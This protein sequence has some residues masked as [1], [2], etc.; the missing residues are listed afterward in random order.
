M[1]QLHFVILA[2]GFTAILGKLI[3][4]PPVEITVWRTA[5]AAVGLAII[6]LV[7]GTPLRLPRRVALL[8]LG[9]GL[10]IGWHWMLFFLSA[11]LATASVSL[12]ALPTVMIWCSL[13]EPLVNGTRRWSTTRQ[14]D[15]HRPW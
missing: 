5:L 7:S 6:A 13:L 8:I 4:L 15:E 12:A 9:T 14:H 10:I 2:W 3:T 1:V 11:R